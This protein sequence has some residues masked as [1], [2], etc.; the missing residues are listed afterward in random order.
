MTKIQVDDAW[1]Y[2][3]TLKSTEPLFIVHKINVTVKQI[4]WPSR[5]LKNMTYFRLPLLT[6][7]DDFNLYFLS[8][9]F[10]GIW[11]STTVKKATNKRGL[12][13]VKVNF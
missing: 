3:N 11:A 8:H 4:S 10:T 6:D 1:L 7:N 5:Q 12:Y 9:N 13:R 2:K